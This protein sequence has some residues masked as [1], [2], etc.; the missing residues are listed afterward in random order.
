MKAKMRLKQ[1]GWGALLALALAL[2]SPTF[3]KGRD[4]VMGVTMGLSFVVLGAMIYAAATSGKDKKKEPEPKDVEARS[5][6]IEPQLW[7]H[8]SPVSTSF[9]HTGK[10]Q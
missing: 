9:T 8:L 4:Y 2:P 5:F 1:A 3:A 10:G 6:S 7:S